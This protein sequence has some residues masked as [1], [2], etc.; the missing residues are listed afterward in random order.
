MRGV[1][2]HAYPA[3]QIIKSNKSVA[4]RL[5]ALGGVGRD[6]HIIAMSDSRKLQD[7]KQTDELPTA[8]T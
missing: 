7:Q 1:K 6:I 3:K 8:L 2:V 5:G 4:L